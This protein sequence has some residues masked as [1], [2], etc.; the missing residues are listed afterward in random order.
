MHQCILRSN[1]AVPIPGIMAPGILVDDQESELV[2]SRQRPTV[3]I[4]D[5]YHPSA[6]K[7]AQK[8]FNTILPADPECRNWKENA[9]Y[10][11]VRG[12]AISATDIQVARKLRAI[13]KQGVGIDKIDQQACSKSGIAILNTPGVNASAVAELV[14]ALTLAVA[15]E[16]GSIQVR[17]SRGESVHKQDCSGLL[18][19]NKTLGLIGMGNIGKCVARMFQG[20]FGAS[21]IAYDPYLPPA[22]WNDVDHIRA[23][24]PAEVIA[25]ADILSLHVPLNESSRNMISYRELSTMKSSAILINAARG[26]IVNEPDLCRALS[27]GLIWGAGLDCHEQEPPTHFRYAQ[28]WSHPRVVSTPHIGAATSDTQAATALAAVERL[29]EHIVRHG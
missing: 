15:R 21:V 27:E 12:S 26:G 4:L 22:A 25:A 3:Y 23:S 28:L 8:L 10:V 5:E 18:L 11:L 29:H 16:I 19:T 1:L 17:Q 6:I 7:R 20:A 9:E 24:T 13:G 14:L 2:S